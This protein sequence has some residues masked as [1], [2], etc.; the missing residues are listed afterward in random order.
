MHLIGPV[1]RL[2]RRPATDALSGLT[3]AAG[4]RLSMTGQVLGGCIP[5]TFI[6]FLVALP[7]KC[8][9]S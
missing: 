3:G 1:S 6:Q 5:E 9:F 4:L 8:D 7:I 2:T